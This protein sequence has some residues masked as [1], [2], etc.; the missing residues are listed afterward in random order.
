MRVHGDPLQP[1][2]A[3]DRGRLERDH[4]RQPPRRQARQAL[5]GPERLE[6]RRS[7]PVEGDG[8]QPE[9]HERANEAMARGLFRLAAR[10]LA[11]Y[12]DPLLE[13]ALD[14][15][16]EVATPDV[17]APLHPHPSLR[18]GGGDAGGVE[19]P[20]PT[21]TALSRAWRAVRVGRE[22]LEPSTL[23]LRVSCSAS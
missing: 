4:H 8:R 21:P 1:P 19:R 3:D 15:D 17:V 14:P 22:G 12:I 23:R 10:E 20:P 2:E 9:P 16:A 5:P 7:H 13:G 6:E 18:P 11:L